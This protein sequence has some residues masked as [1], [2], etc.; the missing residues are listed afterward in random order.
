M[1]I[2]QLGNDWPHFEDFKTWI[3]KNKP[4]YFVEMS[5][6]CDSYLD[7]EPTTLGYRK[8]LEFKHLWQEFNKERRAKRIR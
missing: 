5:K 4:E 6:D 7:G 2:I 1:R 3:E 8:H